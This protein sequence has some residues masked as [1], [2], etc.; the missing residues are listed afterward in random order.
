MRCQSFE[1]GVFMREVAMPS[2]FGVTLILAAL[3][4]GVTGARALNVESPSR[5]RRA[6]RECRNPRNRPR[7]DER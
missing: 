6:R 2:V 3:V 5:T 4:L 7:A 1:A